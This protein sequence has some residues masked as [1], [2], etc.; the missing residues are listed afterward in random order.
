MKLLT[1]CWGGNIT[2]EPVQDVS[3]NGPQGLPFKQFQS[4]VQSIVYLSNSNSCRK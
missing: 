3:G 4:C 2:G 1:S